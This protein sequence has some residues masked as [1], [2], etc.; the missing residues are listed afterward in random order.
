[1]PDNLDLHSASH[2][3]LCAAPHSADPSRNMKIEKKRTGLRPTRSDRRPYN[4]DKPKKNA[5]VNNQSKGLVNEVLMMY[6]IGSDH[7]QDTSFT[8]GSKTDITAPTPVHTAC[9][10]WKNIGGNYVHAD[11]GITRES[12][13]REIVTKKAHT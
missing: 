7:I 2:M 5:P 4:G 3:K 1:M 8:R 11:T 12:V 9:T 10:Y 6:A 13:F